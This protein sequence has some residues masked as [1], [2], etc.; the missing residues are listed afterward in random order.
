MLWSQEICTF[1]FVFQKWHDEQGSKGSTDRRPLK[2]NVLFLARAG[3]LL[4]DQLEN[5][6]WW[7]R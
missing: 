3:A 6:V 1:M 4:F 2:T 7:K 5:Y